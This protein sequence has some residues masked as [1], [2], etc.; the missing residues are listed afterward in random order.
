[1][2]K[3]V[4]AIAEDI[5]KARADFPKLSQPVDAISGIKVGTR[6]RFSNWTSALGKPEPLTPILDSNPWHTRWTD[7]CQK[8]RFQVVL[9]S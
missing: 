1:V 6:I 4:Q 5:T 7:E 3:P 2:V 9:L 8:S